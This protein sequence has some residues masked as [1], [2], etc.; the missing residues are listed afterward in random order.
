MINIIKL[1]DSGQ[2]SNITNSILRLLPE[3]FGIEEAIVE[4]AGGSGNTD[5]YAAYRLDEPVGFISI[6]AINIYTSEIYVTAVLKEYQHMGIGKKLLETAQEELINKNVKFL[7]VKTLGDSHP[8]EYY[9]KT[10]KFYCKMGFYP[11]E[12]LKEIWGEECPCLI[13]VK[14]L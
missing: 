14:A 1:T 13:M 7:M 8:D 4:Y 2:K 6:K 11:L 3:W 9:M 12:E 10:R 5:F